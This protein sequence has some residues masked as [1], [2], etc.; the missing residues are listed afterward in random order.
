MKTFV[1]SALA[2]SLSASL[3]FAAAGGGS[4]SSGSATGASS[5]T[6]NSSAG[7][8]GNSPLKLNCK[9]GEVVKTVKKDGKDA[10]ECVKVTGSL[11]PDDDLYHQGWVLAKAGQYDWAIEV[12]ASVKDQTNPDVLTMLGYSNRKAGRVDVGFNFYNKALAINPDHVRAH[13]YLGEGLVAQGKIELAKVQLGEV[14]RICGNTTCEEY[15]DL[16]K[17]ILGGKEDA[18]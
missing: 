13:E 2:L 5:G 16:S 14:K 11:V 10:K 9:N 4:T 15:Q 18:L 8:S 1:I 17:A 7:A 12:L 6:S 3:A